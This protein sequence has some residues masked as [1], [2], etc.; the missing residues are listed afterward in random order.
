[1]NTKRWVAL[2]IFVGLF[3]FYSLAQISTSSF[4]VPN[5]REW[6]EEVYQKGA[7]ERL[8][9]LEVE[10]VIT[11]AS[12]GGGL[13]SSS[14]YNHDTF[15]KQLEHAYKDER[16]KG[17]VLKVNSPGGGVVES[18]EIYQTIRDLKAEHDKPLVV[19]MSNT[20]ASGGYYISAL[21]DE[22]YAN[23][24]TITGS[25]GVIIS[26]LNYQELA[27]K[28]GVKDQTFTSGPHKDIMSPMKEM[29]A[30]ERQIMQSIVDE[31]YDNFIDVIVE[32]RGMSKDKVLQL[33]DGRIYTGTQA[34]EV[35][36]VDELGFLDDAIEGATALAKIENPTV[37]RYELSGW[38]AF[39]FMKSQFI[40]DYFAQQATFKKV[41][42]QQHSPS[43]MYLFTW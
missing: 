35:G 27:E 12:Q 15:L 33:A 26:S 9:L 13:F 4:L 22:I 37:I 8:A 25:I 10:G 34:K 28:W 43:F 7:L 5:E 20:A 23:R 39:P 3:L 40:Q 42:S 14:L 11:N 6:N 17:I 16:I 31:M 29:S 36:L 30:E 41:L 38:S 1:M 18:D 2:I 21:A 32:G 24:S 19:Y